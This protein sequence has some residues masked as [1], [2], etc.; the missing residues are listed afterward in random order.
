MRSKDEFA[1]FCAWFETMQ[2]ENS[3]TRAL[4]Y[5]LDSLGLLSHEGFGTRSSNIIIVNGQKASFIEKLT[6]TDTLEAN[7]QTLWNCLSNSVSEISCHCSI[8]AESCHH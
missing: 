1:A 2:S 5:E 3:M 8:V 4:H 6:P 7:R